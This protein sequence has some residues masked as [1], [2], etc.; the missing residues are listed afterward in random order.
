MGGGPTVRD[1]IDRRQVDVV[2]LVF[3]GL[4]FQSIDK[5]LEISLGDAA[6]ELIRR[7]VIKINHCVLPKC[8]RPG[9]NSDMQ[10]Q[11][12]G[13][14]SRRGCGG[15]WRQMQTRLDGSQSS[16]PAAHDRTGRRRLQTRLRQRAATPVI[17]VN[18]LI[19]FSRRA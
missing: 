14:H 6:D 8:R 2:V 5:D 15:L 12:C 13:V 19:M 4:F 10:P 1:H 11:F 9:E 3:R 7:R 18:Q 17:G 16:T